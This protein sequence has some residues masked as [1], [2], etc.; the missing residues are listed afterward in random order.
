[1]TCVLNAFRHHGQG[2][3]TATAYRSSWTSAQRLS[4]SRPGERL[5]ISVATAVDSPCSTPFGITARGT[6]T[7]PCSASAGGGAQR[8]SASRGGELGLHPAAPTP[9]PVLNAFRHH[10]QGNGLLCG[11]QDEQAHVLNAF[12]HHGQGNHRGNSPGRRIHQCSTPFGITARGPS[13]CATSASTPPSA[14]RLSASRPGERPRG[15]M[16]PSRRSAQRLSASRPGEP[17]PIRITSSRRPCAQRLSASRPGELLEADSFFV[18]MPKCSTPFGITARGT[19]DAVK[20]VYRTDSGAQ[21][22]SASRPG[23]RY[24]VCGPGAVCNVLNAFR[25]HG[26]GN[27]AYPTYQA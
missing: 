15:A 19:T 2:N 1:M 8:L 20:Y 26:Q 24:R 3:R 17:W 21:R 5:T 9:A 6:R 27:R 14:Q 12:R 4:A 18:N 16:G 11:A 25:H 10:G 7:P 23:E 22:L 13:T